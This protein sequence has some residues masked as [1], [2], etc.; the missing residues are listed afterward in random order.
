LVKNQK[1]KVFIIT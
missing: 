1:N